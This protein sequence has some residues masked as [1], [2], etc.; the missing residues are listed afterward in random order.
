MLIKRGEG[1]FENLKPRELGRRV[2]LALLRQ[3]I[4]NIHFAV[5]EANNQVM[6]EVLGGLATKNSSLIVVGLGG[7]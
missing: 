6:N 4:G 2:W 7:V 1:I 5:G 3:K